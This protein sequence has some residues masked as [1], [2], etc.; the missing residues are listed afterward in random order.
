[1]KTVARLG[2]FALIALTA[3]GVAT[4]RGQSASTSGQAPPSTSTPAS[5]APGVAPPAD[6]IIGPE[7]V[8]E[9]VFWREK[10]LSGQ[11]MVRPDGMVSLPLINDVQAA[12]LTPDELRQK[13]VE[14]AGRYIENPSAAVIVRQI[15]SRKVY[16][17][18]QVAKPGA[19]PLGGPLTVMQLLSMAGGLN[20]Y[21]DTK[22]ITVMR[23]VS[24]KPVRLPFNYKDVSRGRKLE[25]NILLKPGDTVVV[26]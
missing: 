10:D 7:D 8:L 13:L 17:T 20:E 3:I 23:S 22:N 21:A 14:A 24:G 11:V 6:Y 25:Q 16:V 18:G 19:Y 5:P 2:T 9:V 15:N 1:M 12:G 26:P 4:A